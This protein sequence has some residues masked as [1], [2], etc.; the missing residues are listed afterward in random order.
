MHM[1]SSAVEKEKEKVQPQQCELIKSGNTNCA[2]AAAAAALVARPY[3]NR[4]AGVGANIYE[5]ALRRR[6]R[7]I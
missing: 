4:D 6:R 7:L 5:N 3:I 2:A 1:Y